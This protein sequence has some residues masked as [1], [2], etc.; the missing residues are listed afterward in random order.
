MP[1]PLEGVRV[2]ELAGVGPG[3]HGVMLLADLGADVVRVD[4]PAAARGEDP[5]A[6]AGIGLARNRRSIAIDLKDPQ[7]AELVLA[8]IE[9]ADV[10]VEGFRPGVAERLGLGPEVVTSRAPRVVYARVTGFGQDGPLAPRAGHDLDYLALSGMLDA[11]G[12]AGTP[13]PPPG[14]L[15]ADFGGGGT[16]VAIGVLAA[17]LERERSGLGQVIDVAMVDGVASLSAFTRGLLSI[18]AWTTERGGNLLDGGAPFYACYACEDGRHV[19]VAALEPEFYARLVEGLGMD[20]ADWPQWDRARWPALTA[21][22]RR[23]FADA[24]RDVWAERFADVDACVVP[25]L[26]LAEAPSHPHHIARG[27]YLEGPGSPP[28]PAPR[29]GRTPGAVRRPPPRPG[30]HTDEVLAELDVPA[31]RLADLR[32]RGVIV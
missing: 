12:P 6:P 31:E 18:G 26:D 2:V 14:A 23:R 21:E 5:L 13:P 32:E 16:F 10:L 3:P 8:L 17:L 30:E 1:A 27:T 28:A 11:I 20:G 22:L 9:R 25:V 4:R 19:A 24:P 15:I 7:G 29:L